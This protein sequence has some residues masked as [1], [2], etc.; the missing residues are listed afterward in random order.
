MFYYRRQDVS[1]TNT[2][3]YCDMEQIT[4]VKS[5]IVQSAG[6]EYDLMWYCII[7]C[8]I[9]GFLVQAVGCMTKSLA[10]YDMELNT[11][12]KTFI[13]Q[14]GRCE[15]VWKLKKVCE[16]EWIQKL[17]SQNFIFSLL[18]NEPNKLQC[19]ITLG[20]KGLPLTNTLAYWNYS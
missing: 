19:Y 16:N 12:V 1:M 13:V 9:K 8:W 7:Y 11:A 4:V 2:L 6:C 20:W 17:H 14:F 18:K 5:F 3:A 10:Y 15:R